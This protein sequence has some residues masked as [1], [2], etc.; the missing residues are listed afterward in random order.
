LSSTQSLRIR[1]RIDLADEAGA[2]GP[3]AVLLDAA[4]RSFYIEGVA[5]AADLLPL[6]GQEVEILGTLRGASG[7]AP[8]LRVEA[9][10][11]T[12]RRRMPLFPSSRGWR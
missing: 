4:D 12:G 9:I 8:R 7:P 10:L 11:S 2:D 6:V 1:G 5:S 3:L